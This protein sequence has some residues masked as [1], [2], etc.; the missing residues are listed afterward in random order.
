VVEL[1]TQPDE[2]GR[3]DR[4]FSLAS[5]MVTLAHAL[6]LLEAAAATYRP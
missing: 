3:I 6:D 2:T 5:E 1:L 4:Q